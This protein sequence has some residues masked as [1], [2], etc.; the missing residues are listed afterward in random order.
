M[1]WRFDRFHNAYPSGSPGGL[2]GNQA[3]DPSR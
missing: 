1:N 2:Y 3:D